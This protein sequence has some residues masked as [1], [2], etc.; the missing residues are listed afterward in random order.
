MAKD[1][2]EAKVT[3]AMNVILDLMIEH[4]PGADPS[5]LK[6]LAEA[7]AWLRSPQAPHGG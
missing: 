3:Q 2:D 1:A 6:N 4:G 7:L 5:W